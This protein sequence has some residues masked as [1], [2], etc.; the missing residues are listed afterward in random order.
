VQPRKTLT[1]A[2]QIANV[3]TSAGKSLLE[4]RMKNIVSAISFSVFLY[5]LTVSAQQE[6]VPSFSLGATVGY[7]ANGAGFAFSPNVSIAVTALGFGG[8]DLVSFPYQVSLYNSLGS[9]LA[10]TEV[11][12]GSTLYNQT[13]YQGITS[14]NLIAG[15]T[16]Y[17][18]AVEVG[19]TNGNVWAGNIVGINA[20]GSFSVNSDITYSD[21]VSGFVSG[22]P[23]SNLGDNFP[24][25]ENFQFTVVPEPSVLCFSM[26]G[27][28]GIAWRLRRR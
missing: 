25:D 21:G 4:S 7:A 27:F 8:S 3:M 12:T 9:Q 15:D 26:A 14:V 17:I 5:C 22:L 11:T 23:T 28:L 24:V 10:T 13:Y 2:P 16:Y 18:G 20:G 6:A 19:N 1:L